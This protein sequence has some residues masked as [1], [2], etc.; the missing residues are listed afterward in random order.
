MIIGS[1]GYY[2]SNSAGIP[3]VDHDELSS[4]RYKENWDE[5]VEMLN[6][7]DSQILSLQ[8]ELELLRESVLKAYVEKTNKQCAPMAGM[9]AVHDP[10]YPQVKVG[11]FIICRQN[12]NGVWIQREDTE[13]GGE[14]RDSVFEPFLAQ[15]WK[16]NF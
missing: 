12:D 10:C 4:K 15:F 3:P 1:G 11:N 5:A 6:L 14:F 13:E 7:K 16:E 9:Y 2:G 8:R